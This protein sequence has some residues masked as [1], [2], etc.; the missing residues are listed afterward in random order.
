MFGRATIT[1]GIGPHSSWL[2]CCC[3]S[4]LRGGVVGHF[5]EWQL[6]FYG[7]SSSPV[8]LTSPRRT[9]T[10]STAVDSPAVTVRS[11]AAADEDVSTSDVV[12]TTVDGGVRSN[13]T[14]VSEVSVTVSVTSSVTDQ[15]TESTNDSVATA[16]S[17][18]ASV[19]KNLTVKDSDAEN[20]TQLK[21]GVLLNGTLITLPPAVTAASHDHTTGRL[22]VYNHAAALTT[23][24]MDSSGRSWS[25]VE[26]TGSNRSHE[27]TSSVDSGSQSPEAAVNQT[28]AINTTS[29]TALLYGQV[30]TC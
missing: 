29:S 3:Y 28:D 19:V 8:N 16:S 10:T 20:S 30:G 15:L 24:L 2:M 23:A 21:S 22:G 11:S 18:N 7:T 25:V 4:L 5:D 9:S 26:V 12:A 17:S 14:Y 6:I 1:L 13:V 27:E